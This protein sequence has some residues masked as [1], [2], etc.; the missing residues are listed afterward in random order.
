MVTGTK[1]SSE[2]L[3]ACSLFDIVVMD[4]PPI[5]P[6]QLIIPLMPTLKVLKEIK[7]R[8]SSGPKTCGA[9]Q[10]RVRVKVKQKLVS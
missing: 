5:L 9:R 7:R 8:S 10:A 1:G 6:E 2:Y 4:S 3:S